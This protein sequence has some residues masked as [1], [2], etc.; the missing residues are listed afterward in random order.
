MAAEKTF[1]DEEYEKAISYKNAISTYSEDWV[2]IL[3]SELQSKLKVGDI[4]YVEYFPDSQKHLYSYYPEYGSV[5][6]IGLSEYYLPSD[7][8]T[9]TRT[10]LSIT[11]LNHNGELVDI[12]KD[13]LSI[14]SRGYCM[15]IKKYE[16]NHEESV[17]PL[18][19]SYYLTCETDYNSSQ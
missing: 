4:I 14:Y 17:Y 3:E 6:Q 7:N 9:H 13:N 2:E 10:Q 15:W 5:Q 11:I 18:D 8:K 1:Y 19:N 16:L 12:I